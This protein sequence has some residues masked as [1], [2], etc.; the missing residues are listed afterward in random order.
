MCRPVFVALLTALALAAGS[1]A[2][3]V[4]QAAPEVQAV[5]DANSAFA[6]D[7][8]RQ[9]RDQPGNLFCSPFS[10]SAA[11]AM[12]SAGARGETLAELVRA[13][14]LPEG[15]GAHAAF[16]ELLRGL[17]PGGRSKY[18]LSIA[19]ALWGQQGFPF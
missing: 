1:A 10:I 17:Q 9:L 11:L 7:L 4:P 8:Y 12:T 5:A 3:A 14:H 15:P 2:P 18:E 13:L 16:G 6:L 19:N